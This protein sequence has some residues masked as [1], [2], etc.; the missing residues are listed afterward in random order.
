M[1]VVV[2]NC[3]V[4]VTR[5][6]FSLAHD[7]ESIWVAKGERLEQ[8]RIDH[9]EDRCS[10]TDTQRECKDGNERETG[11]P[12][13]LTNRIVHIASRQFEPRQAPLHTVGLTDLRDAA[14]RA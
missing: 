13:Q 3:Q 14:K 5:L 4:V 10:R 7:D 8:N 12:A 1:M 6:I 2:W 11:R 9:A